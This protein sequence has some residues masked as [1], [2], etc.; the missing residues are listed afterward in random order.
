MR[1]YVD[2]TFQLFDKEHDRKPFYALA[3]IGIP[4]EEEEPIRE[5]LK[6]KGHGEPIHGTEL[7]QKRRRTQ[8]PDGNFKEDF[9]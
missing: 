9:P 6:A 1:F 4:F 2:E 5:F 8:R 7:L 3:A